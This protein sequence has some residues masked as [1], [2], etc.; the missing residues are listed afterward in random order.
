MEP[1]KWFVIGVHMCLVYVRTDIL[2]NCPPDSLALN[3]LIFYCP[4]QELCRLGIDLP[5][6]QLETHG[7]KIE[8]DLQE[9]LALR[10]IILHLRAQPV[11]PGFHFTCTHHFAH[12]KE[13]MAD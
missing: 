7:R 8:Q 13:G 11:L 10:P 2:L 1:N 4:G 6:G 3:A 9:M 12:G 5:V